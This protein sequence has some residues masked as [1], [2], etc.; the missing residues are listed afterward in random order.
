VD[1]EAAGATM[2]GP[3]VSVSGASL[4]QVS[5]AVVKIN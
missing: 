1:L 3:K 4:T 2:A 5:G